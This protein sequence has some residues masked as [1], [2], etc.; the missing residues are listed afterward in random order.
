MYVVRNAISKDTRD[1]LFQYV[2]YPG[3]IHPIDPR[4]HSTKVGYWYRR[5]AAPNDFLI[6]VIPHAD[7]PELVE[8]IHQMV[9]EFWPGA[10]AEIRPYRGQPGIQLSCYHK[11]AYVGF[12][13]DDYVIR[14]GA[15]SGNVIAKCT[16][17]ALLNDDFT[18]GELVVENRNP[19]LNAGDVIIFDCENDVHEVLPVKSGVRLSGVIWFDVVED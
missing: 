15:P 18:G 13:V 10:H 17:V 11:D 7:H 14:P 6:R 3:I 9:R 12:H 5:S 4:D 2:P 1:A 8:C 16:F 19:K